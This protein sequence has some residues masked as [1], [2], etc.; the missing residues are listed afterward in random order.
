MLKALKAGEM[1]SYFKG[2]SNN[3]TKQ[4][5]YKNKKIQIVKKYVIILLM[6]IYKK[7]SII[8]KILS[9]HGTE[10]NVYILTIVFH[11][12]TMQL[13]LFDFIVIK[14]ISGKFYKE[15]VKYGKS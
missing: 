1:T 11:S 12:K 8:T 14:I 4:F 13:I 3:I 10:K 15:R 6:W 5:K 7:I 9:L 2:P